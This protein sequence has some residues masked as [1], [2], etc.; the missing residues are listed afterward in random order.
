MARIGRSGSPIVSPTRG[1][2]NAAHAAIAINGRKLPGELQRAE[3][4]RNL[5][6]ARRLLSVRAA[7]LPQ[8]E[9]WRTIAKSD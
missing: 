6:T 2:A 3:R 4:V 1:S 7:I 9:L 5:E 8:I